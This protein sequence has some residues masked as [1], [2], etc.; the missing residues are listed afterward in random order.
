MKKGLWKC[1]G[2]Q[3]KGDIITLI[4]KLREKNDKSN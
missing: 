1:F 2:C 3:E 4:K